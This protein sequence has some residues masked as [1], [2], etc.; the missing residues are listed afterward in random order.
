MNSGWAMRDNVLICRTNGVGNHHLNIVTSMF[1]FL[2]SQSKGH[3][4][5]LEMQIKSNGD[6]QGRF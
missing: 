5:L 6:F 4:T 1:V 3:L 2:V